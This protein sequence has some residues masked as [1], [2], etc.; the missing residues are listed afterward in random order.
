LHLS[1]TRSVGASS[2]KNLGRRTLSRA[3]VGRLGKAEGDWELEVV[4]RNPG[5]G[6]FSIQPHRQ[7]VVERTFGWL[8][9]NRRLSKDYERKVQTSETI[10]QVTLIRLLVTRPGCDA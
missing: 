8:C 3:G 2:Q 1:W 4:E 5:M 6:G 9:R 10:L 7:V